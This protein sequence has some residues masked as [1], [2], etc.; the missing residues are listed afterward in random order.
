M[1]TG[2]Y[3][4][5]HGLHWIKDGA[6]LAPLDTCF[7][8]LAEE[9]KRIGFNT[10]AFV[11]N[12]GPL[13]PSVGLNQGFEIYDASPRCLMRS[14]QPL[15]LNYL[16]RH[17][18]Y[19]YQLLTKS[20]R[21]A[22]QMFRL[23]Q[24]WLSNRLESDSRPF[25]LFINLMDTHAS[26]VPPPP[27]NK[28][29]PGWKLNPEFPVKYSGAPEKYFPHIRS[30]YDGEILYADHAFGKFIYFLKRNYIYR[31]TCIIVTS[32][33]GDMLGEHNVWGHQP[34]YLIY[35]PVVSI[36]LIIK[37]AQGTSL[38]DIYFFKQINDI[39]YFIMNSIKKE[40]VDYSSRNPVIQFFKHDHP[41]LIYS[42]NYKFTFFQRTNEKVLFDLATDPNENNDI[43]AINNNFVN[44]MLVEYDEFLKDHPSLIRSI[45]LD[46]K[47]AE[48][49]EKLRALGYIK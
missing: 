12:Y 17:A 1:F 10:A 2:L 27:F 39:Y 35:E 47:S 48:E 7:I 3:P 41:R 23:A 6:E 4:N 29:F 16:K 19:Y 30:L 14:G 18:F 36:P 20:Y 22:G 40:R 26:F 25:F 37:P 38:D 31:N 5:E 34:S 46:K 15:I 13:K 42:N 8:T 49:L 11:S 43:S 45:D 32:D 9:L 33:H 44:R 24:D 21:P 28:E